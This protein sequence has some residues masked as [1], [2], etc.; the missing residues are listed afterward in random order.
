MTEPRFRHKVTI[1]SIRIGDNPNWA[2]EIEG[3]HYSCSLERNGRY[4]HT[5]FSKGSGHKG[6]WPNV[7]EVLWALL[8]DADALEYDFDEWCDNLGYDNDS[9]KAKKIY[10]LCRDLG[11]KVIDFLGDDLEAWKKELQRHFW[12]LE[13]Y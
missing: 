5:F 9:I 2:G 13:D 1:Q 12:G 8:M 4:M 6:K 10:D 7:K 11:R 3:D